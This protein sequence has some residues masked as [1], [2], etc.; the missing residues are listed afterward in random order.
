M[1]T[2]ILITVPKLRNYCHLK[3]CLLYRIFRC[4]LLFG[5]ILA[6]LYLAHNEK[7]PKLVLRE[8]QFVNSSF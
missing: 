1:R 2:G 3:G 8:T 4:K 6:P 5:F 7:S